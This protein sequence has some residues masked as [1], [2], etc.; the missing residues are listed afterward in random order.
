[1][2]AN[3]KT[4]KTAKMMAINRYQ[5][6][7]DRRARY[8]K[9][10]GLGD[11][12]ELSFEDTPEPGATELGLCRSNLNS[13]STTTSDISCLCRDIKSSGRLSAAG[14]LS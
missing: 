5:F 11:Q 12:L 4:I 1:M 8:P 14:S 13:R 2:V 10:V 6:E 9:Y 7:P 3:S